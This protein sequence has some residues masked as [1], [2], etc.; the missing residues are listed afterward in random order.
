MDKNAIIN[1]AVQQAY[2]NLKSIVD[3]KI[4]GVI[5]NYFSLII[6]ESKFNSLKDYVDE[7]IDKTFWKFCNELSNKVTKDDIEFIMYKSFVNNN[8]SGELIEDCFKII[9][10]ILINKKSSNLT[11]LYSLLNPLKE[12][13]SKEEYE[14]S[15]DT[16]FD[17]LLSYYSVI[18]K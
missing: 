18:R 3:L 7:I 5:G 17:I 10:D 11:T 9:N 1:E 14:K 16:I 2:N 12:N 13:Y 8:P 4:L 6:P 15:L